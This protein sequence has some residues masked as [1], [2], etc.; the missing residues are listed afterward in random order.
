[1][2]QFRQFGRV[3]L[4]RGQVDRFQKDEYPRIKINPTGHPHEGRGD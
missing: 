4:A 1:M 2:V 3:D